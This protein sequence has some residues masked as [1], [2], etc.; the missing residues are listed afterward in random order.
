MNIEID[1]QIL[2]VKVGINSDIKIVYILY[3]DYYTNFNNRYDPNAIHPEL[4]K[5]FSVLREN[6]IRSAHK[7]RM[8]GY[9]I[10]YITEKDYDDMDFSDLS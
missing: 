2:N 5:K 8:L 1:E 10:S 9:A 6:V 7:I 4:K 3:S